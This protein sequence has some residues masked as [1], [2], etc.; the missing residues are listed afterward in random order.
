MGTGR[1]GSIAKQAATTSRARLVTSSK[2]PAE[3]LQNTSMA[4]PVSV[5]QSIGT[6]LV[7][8]DL[9]SRMTSAA[10]TRPEHPVSPPNPS[11]S[12]AGMSASNSAVAARRMPR[13]LARALDEV[14]TPR[15]AV[16]LQ[17]LLVRLGVQGD[18]T[19]SDVP[20]AQRDRHVEGTQ[21]A[22]ASRFTVF[23]MA[24]PASRL[25]TSSS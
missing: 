21:A 18:R 14:E 24:D 8:P 15:L 10:V 25:A 3:S 7:R 22:V 17:G 13:A 23:S 2:Q 20:P 1:F 12:M 9:A 5:S 11:C 6:G 4:P 16:V 19:R